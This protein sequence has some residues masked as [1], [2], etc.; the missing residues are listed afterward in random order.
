MLRRTAAK[1]RLSE[2]R[3]DAREQAVGAA[4][5]LASAAD[6]VAEAEMH[7]RLVR[8]VL[9]LPEPYRTVVLRRYFQQLS[10]RE[11]ASLTGTPAGTV[12]AQL[13]R[14]LA[15]LRSSLRGNDA[16]AW[17]APLVALAGAGSG[18]AGGAVAAGV[19][20]MTQAKTTVLAGLA[21]A[22][23]IG[24][25]IWAAIRDAAEPARSDAIAGGPAAASGAPGERKPRRTRSRPLR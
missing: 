20:L 14:A 11:I 16:D 9:G 21:I 17:P 12:R 24:I 19:V 1:L 8:S 5:P 7:E 25:L 6:L 15:L 4:H 13:S 23:A 2:A 3:R 18:N 22:V 10:P